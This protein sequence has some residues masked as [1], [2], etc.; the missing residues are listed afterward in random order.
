MTINDPTTATPVEIDTELARL[1]IEAERARCELHALTQQ[2]HRLAQYGGTAHLEAL[3]VRIDTARATIIAYEAAG[4]PL[5]EEYR[6]RGGW[7]RA[8]LVTNTGGHVHRTTACRTC[9]PTTRFAWL[10]QFSG[11]TEEEIVDEAG[12]AACTECYP[13]APVAVRARPSR[14]TTPQQQARAQARAARAKATAAKAITAPEGTPLRTTGY[15]RVDTEITARRS[16]ADAL[17][18]IRYLASADIAGNRQLITEYRRDADLIL[19]ALCAKHGRTADD[20]RVELASAVEAKW[21][22]EHSRWT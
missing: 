5:E 14:I 18:Y 9:Y 1:N 11:R 7:T 17:S 3:R 2:A 6:R 20:M 22:R 19:D 13:N 4:E 16:Y 15:G 12:A 21:K 8:W 10:T